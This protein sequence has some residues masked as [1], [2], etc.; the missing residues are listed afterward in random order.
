MSV[1]TYAVVTSVYL[2]AALVLAVRLNEQQAIAVRHTIVL[3]ALAVPAA[4]VGARVLDMLEYADRYRS[5]DDVLGRNGSS[6][7]GGLFAGF[8]VA[9]AYARSQHI[10]PLRL[11]DSGAPV[12]AFGEAATRVGCF[13]NGCCYGVESSGPLAVTFP[14]ASFA[15]RDQVANGLLAP[16]AAHSLPVHPVQLYSAL[17]MMVAGVWLMRRFTHRRRDGE[18]FFAFLVLYGLLRLLMAPLRVEALGSMRAF[19]VAFIVLG[20]LGLLGARERLGDRSFGRA[21]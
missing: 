20:G 15:Y 11:L 7:Y 3:F 2:V 18:V 10:A 14:P 5:L 4:T 17:S 16:S 8:A 12:I 9:W 13:L 19:S 21:R 1:S 6:I